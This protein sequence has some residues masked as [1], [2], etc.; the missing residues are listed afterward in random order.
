MNDYRTHGLDWNALHAF[1]VI[2]DEGTL[3]RAAKRLGVS[4]PTLGRRLDALEA[5]LGAT[6]FVRGRGGMVPTERGLRLLEHARAVKREADAFSLAAAGDR[7]QRRGTVRLSASRI[8]SHV[9]L[10]PILAGIA[11][12]EP[13]IEIELVATDEVSDLLVRDADIALRMVRPVQP[14]VIAAKVGELPL[15]AFAARSYVERH[16]LPDPSVA[17]ARVFEGHRL[18]GY[19]RSP[20]IS[21][22]LRAAGVSLDR[23][24]FALRT[25]DQIVYAALVRAGAGIGFLAEPAARGLVPVPLPVSIPSLPIWLAGHRELRTGAAVRYVADA[26]RNGLAGGT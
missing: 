2:A 23:H 21:D 9:L 14:E 6:L 13:G 19:D 22:G 4:Q 16:G 15:G 20:L 12:Q 3:T 18:V 7:S 17:P 5:H 1:V 11:E 26:L 25:D 24:A 10:P 8:V